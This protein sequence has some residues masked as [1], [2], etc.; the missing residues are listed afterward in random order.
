MA[1]SLLRTCTHPGCGTLTLGDTCV[2]HE[3]R[4]VR[5]FPRG[6]PFVRTARTE[7]GPAARAPRLERRAV[8]VPSGSA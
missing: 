2:E 8:A 4:T 6:R 1:G 3:R 7:A 5:D